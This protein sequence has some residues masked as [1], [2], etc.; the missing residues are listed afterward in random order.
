MYNNT[1]LLSSQSYQNH[2][3]TKHVNACAFYGAEDL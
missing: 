2:T 3:G 1:K